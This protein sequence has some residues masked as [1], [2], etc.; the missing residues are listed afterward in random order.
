MEYLKKNTTIGP[1][2]ASMACVAIV[3]AG[4]VGTAT[5]PA[6]AA[7][8]Y[9][10]CFAGAGAEKITYFSAVFLGDYFYDS[11]RAQLEFHSYLEAIGKSPG[12][13]NTLCFFEN[14]RREAEL[15]LQYEALQKQRYPYA[16]WSVVHTEWKPGFSG[17]LPSG[18]GDDSH[19]RESG[20]DGCYFGE[21]PDDVSPPARSRVQEVGPTRRA[22]LGVQIQ[23]VGEDIA[24]SLRLLKPAGALVAEVFPDGPADHAGVQ[25][26][27]VLLKFDGNYIPTVRDLPRMIAGAEAGSEVEFGLWRDGRMETVRI[28]LG[29]LEKAETPSIPSAD[30]SPS[31][32]IC[33]TPERWCE[34]SAELPIG[35]PCGCF[36]PSGPIGGITVRSI[37]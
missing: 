33:S 22:W 29:E 8:D 27:D 6:S 5:R 28:I 12:F 20:G 30:T 1:S 14:T 11:R 37:P 23:G 31:T 13:F 21:C 10:Y 25:P 19:G 18:D 2:A 15:E 24:D 17:P 32:L 3:F 26:G 7:D 34:M 36:G 16:D 35:Q 9:M 4:I